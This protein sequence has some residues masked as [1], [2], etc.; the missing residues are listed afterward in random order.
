MASLATSTDVIAGS[1]AKKQGK[2]ARGRD[3]SV[4]EKDDAPQPKILKP[5]N[6]TTYLIQ[7]RIVLEQEGQLRKFKD[8]IVGHTAGYVSREI[9]NRDLQLGALQRPEL[10]GIVPGDEVDFLPSRRHKLFIKDYDIPAALQP[11]VQDFG[12][13]TR[14]SISVVTDKLPTADR[15][16]TKP[17]VIQRSHIPAGWSVEWDLL[18]GEK[19]IPDEVARMVSGVLSGQAAGVQEEGQDVAQQA[20]TASHSDSSPPSTPAPPLSNPQALEPEMTAAEL[21]TK[22]RALELELEIEKEQAVLKELDHEEANAPTEGG[23]DPTDVG[24]SNLDE[25]DDVL[26]GALAPNSDETMQFMEA[27]T[28]VQAVMNSILSP[29]RFALFGIEYPSSFD[30]S[31]AIQAMKENMSKESLDNQHSD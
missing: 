14:R 18:Q 13:V 2:R 15:D 11:T 3:S 7:L 26:G 31:Q 20:P 28:S 9:A 27:L 21:D 4:E 10:F 24:N 30:L 16:E 17:V 19:V 12:K 1:A 29:E 5:Q 8:W 22:I 6:E 25:G 23:V